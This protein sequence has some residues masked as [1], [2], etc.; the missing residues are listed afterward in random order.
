LGYARGSLDQTRDH[1]ADL[2]YL[3]VE[4]VTQGHSEETEVTAE[5]QVIFRS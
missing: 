2:Q 3:E 5:Q 4:F 1:L